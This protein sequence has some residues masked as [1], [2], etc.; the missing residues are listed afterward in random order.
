MDVLQAIRARRA[1]RAFTDEALDRPTVQVLVDAAVQAPSAMN[2]QPWTF[3]VALGRERVADIARRAKAHLV[4]SLDTGPGLL[5]R[6][7]MLHDPHFDILYGAP[8][9]IVVYAAVSDAPAALVR[10]DQ[11][12]C[13][14]A[15]NL[16]LAARAMNLGSCWIGFA[17]PWLDLPATKDEFGLSAEHVAVAP[18][19]VGYPQAWPDATARHTPRIVW[20]D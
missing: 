9:L 19:V 15:Q 7:D 14:A 17:R 13:L 12:C 2:L 3:L 11:D 8:A 18:I 6:T 1:V 16:M 20:C 10:P 5:R 4:A